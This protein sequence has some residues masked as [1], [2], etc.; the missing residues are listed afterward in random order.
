[1]STRVKEK[2]MSCKQLVELV[3][4]YLEGAMAAPERARFDEHLAACDGCT[5]Y[6]EQ[7]R[8]TITALGHIPP[9]SLS[10]AAEEALLSAF[11]SWRGSGRRE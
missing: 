5:R 2:P 10:P 8:Q 9:A 3:T 4:E 6:V 11:R 1:M 7:M